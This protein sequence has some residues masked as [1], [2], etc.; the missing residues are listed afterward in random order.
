MPRE[1]IERMIPEFK[2]EKTVRALD[3]VASM[4]LPH[5]GDTVS[6]DVQAGLLV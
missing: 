5:A 1:G 3:R 6:L 2:R 4:I